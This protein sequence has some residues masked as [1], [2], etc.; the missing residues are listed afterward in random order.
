LAIFSSIIVKVSYQDSDTRYAKVEKEI[1]VYDVDRSFKAKL[2]EVIESVP[3]VIVKGR[4]G[5]SV[6]QADSRNVPFIKSNSVQLIVTSPP[7]LNA[8]DYHK[9]HRQ[10]IHWIG[11][12]FVFARDIE[13]GSHDEFTRKNAKPNQYFIDM[14]NCFGEWYRVLKMG[15]VCVVVVGDSIVSKKPVFVGDAFVDLMTAIGFELVERSIRSLH[16]TKRSFNAR[17]RINQEH[18]LIF[19]KT[20]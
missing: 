5:T 11:G 9:Y 2:F 14:T 20:R 3:K 10:R 15:G 8:Y 19:R 6:V 1:N 13:I 16:S 12:D 17:G 18:V 4:G 7:Y